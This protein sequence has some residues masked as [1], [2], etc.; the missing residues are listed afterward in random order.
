MNI[1]DLTD[2][3]TEIYGYTPE[4]ADRFLCS[5]TET[6]RYAGICALPGGAS[7]LALYARGESENRRV[8]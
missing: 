4:E 5:V 7:E 8:A 6:E 2:E 3:L 1:G